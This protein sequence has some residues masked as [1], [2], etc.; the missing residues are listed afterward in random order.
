MATK[1]GT[2]DP[3]N[4]EGTAG[5]DEIR[6]LAGA[7]TLFGLG[8]ADLIWGGDDNDIVEGGDG[9]DVIYDKREV[10]GLAVVDESTD[11]L[12]G[13]DGNDVI[14]GGSSDR[15][16]GGAGGN[17][18]AFITANE[19]GS[20]GFSCDFGKMDAGQAASMTNGGL[21]QN[22]ERVQLLGSAF[23]DNVTGTS[24]SDIFDGAGGSDILR[25]GAGNDILYGGEDEDELTG[26][27][28][29]DRLVGGTDDDVYIID[30]DDVIVENQ[31][32]G[33][34][35]VVADFTYA[36]G[37]HVENLTLKGSGDID[38]TGNAASNI[39]RGNEGD[40]H[41]WGGARSDI[42]WGRDGDDVLDGG[43]GADSLEG[44]AGN[45]TFVL[46]DTSAIDTVTD[47]STIR[48]VIA[49]DHNAFSLTV[50]EL[51]P[52]KFHLGAAAADA[53]DRLIYDPATGALYFDSDGN[54]GIAQIQVAALTA[55]LALSA[56][57]F[58]VI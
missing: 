50:G 27:A 51:A 6:G 21:I 38:G 44:G 1:I 5:N 7:D 40:N 32:E 47:F 24:R 49:L 52:E 4:L 46:G 17:D 8:G 28:G 20:G 25:G 11:R 57:D 19:T 18:W 26:G 10:G 55:G 12:R 53:D 37:K 29:R 23:R 56:A 35:K 2:L 45:D 42:L 22:V 36:L 9:D 48:D 13:G 15:I 41:L 14:Y 34:D 54:G 39:I 16:D 43:S 33:L 31:D 3:D 30:A 58:V